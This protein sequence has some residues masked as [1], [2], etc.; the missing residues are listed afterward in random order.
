MGYDIKELYSIMPIANIP[1][2]LKHGILS[3][4]QVARLPHSDISM[5]EVQSKRHEKSVPGGLKLHQYVNLYFCARNPMMYARREQVDEICVLRIN[6]NVGWLDGVYSCDGN[7][8]SNYTH[9]YTQEEWNSKLDFAMIFAKDWTDANELEQMR[10]KRVKCAEVLVPNCV[11]PSF[12]VGALVGNQVA[13][14]NLRRTG[15]ALDIQEEKDI[16]FL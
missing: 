10:K 12:I 9:F 3:H 14:V 16:F 13:A 15:F 1:S 4:E 7:A 6:V 5:A 8:A 2:V 11:E